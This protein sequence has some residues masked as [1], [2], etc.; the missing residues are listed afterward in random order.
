MLVTSKCENPIRVG[1]TICRPGI[2]TPVTREELEAFKSCNMGLQLYDL[3]FKVEEE[4]E[5]KAS[6]EIVD[7]AIDVGA[8]ELREPES[9]DILPSWKFKPGLHKVKHRGGGQWFVMLGNEKIKGPLSPED[10]I[11]YQAIE[12]DS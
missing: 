9:D 10:R 2:E 5:I 7:E 8:D 6:F 12:N 3:F 1:R 4:P 11:K